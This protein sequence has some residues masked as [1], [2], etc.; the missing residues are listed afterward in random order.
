MEFH[1]VSSSRPRTRR[2][3]LSGYPLGLQP[4]RVE[5]PIDVA[6][7]GGRL[8]KGERRGGGDEDEVGDEGEE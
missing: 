5:K 3:L 7:N 2:M 4:V 6:G 8:H 1:P